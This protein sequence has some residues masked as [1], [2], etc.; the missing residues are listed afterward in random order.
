MI[1]SFPIS[2][3]DAVFQPYIRVI[4]M[5]HQALSGYIFEQHLIET[6][7]TTSIPPNPRPS[8]RGPA[9]L[10]WPGTWP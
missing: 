3:P 6:P 9:L 10:T 2:V 7:S 5:T 4:M 1:P 8:N